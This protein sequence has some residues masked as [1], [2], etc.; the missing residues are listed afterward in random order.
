[1]QPNERVKAVLESG[2]RIFGENRIQE[3]QSK[4]PDFKKQYE[5]R[6]AAYYWSFADK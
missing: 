6:G 4:W 3:A 5:R 2:H 1:M